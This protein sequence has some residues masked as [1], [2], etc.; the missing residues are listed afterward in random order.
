M[1]AK[2]AAIYVRVSTIEQDTDLQETEL[3]EYTE[4]RAGVVSFTPD[5]GQSGA[6]ND[7]PALTAIM[8]DLRRLVIGVVN[9]NHVAVV[10]RVNRRTLIRRLRF[11]LST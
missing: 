7:R 3:R 5:R 2:R 4:S 1:R 9:R 10:S 8:S 6:K 11:C